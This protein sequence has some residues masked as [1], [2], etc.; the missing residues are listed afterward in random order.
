MASQQQHPQRPD[1]AWR[2]GSII[3][4]ELI[5]PLEHS[6]GLLEALPQECV[7]ILISQDCDVLNEC[8]E[9]EPFVE[10]LIAIPKSDEEE[11]KGLLFGKHPR[12]LQIKISRPGDEPQL[13]EI[14]IHNRCRLRREVLLNGL[15]AGLLDSTLT[16]VIARW[17]AKKYTR[18]AFPDEFN[19]RCKDAGKKLAKLFKKQG[20]LLTGL[21]IRLDPDDAELPAEDDYRVMLFAT[22]AKTVWLDS[23]SKTDAISL[24]EQV[25][26]ALNDCRGLVVDE[27]TL[28]PEDRFS[29]EDIRNTDRWDYDYLTYRSEPDPPVIPLE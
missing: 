15:P 19:I 23:K 25:G 14:N 17:V 22:C 28:V 9:T 6:L 10:F 26:T 8:Y 27:A 12:N 4:R 11:D 5:A 29:L 1:S 16:D 24:V 13:L 3:S 2:Q 21:F 7:I 20:E 18:P